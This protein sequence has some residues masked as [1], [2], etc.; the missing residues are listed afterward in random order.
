[1][2]DF[3][4]AWREFAF[5]FLRAFKAE[6]KAQ[7]AEIA[8]L[9]IFISATGTGLVGNL[10]STRGMPFVMVNGTTGPSSN[11]ALLILNARV[12][13]S[14]QHL[15]ESVERVLKTLPPQGIATE[16]VNLDCFSPGRPKPTH[17]LGNVG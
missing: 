1:M 5:D 13:L 2:A 6:F 16:L 3:P 10:T 8:H 9:K 12:H 17:R 7:H 11:Y 14:P 15:R 4:K